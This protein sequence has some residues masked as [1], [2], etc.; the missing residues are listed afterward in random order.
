MRVRIRTYAL[1]AALA[2]SAA[3]PAIPAAALAQ[4]AGAP[5]AQAETLFVEAQKALSR[6]DAALAESILKDALTLDPAFTSAIWQLAQIYESQGKLDYARELLLR[7]LDQDPDASWAR[8]RLAKLEGT[9]ARALLADARAA[10]NAGEFDAA[11]PRLSSYLGIEPD[12]PAALVS[13][14]KCQLAKGR[15]KTAREYLARARAIDPDNAEL[16]SLTAVMTSGD[17]KE[18][19]EKLL[20]AAQIALLDTTAESP[21]KARAALG[22]LIAEDP[23][24]SWAKERLADLDRPSEAKPA[25]AHEGPIP[26]T[27]VVR[28]R[29]AA[30]RS[31]GVL[32]AAGRF[33][34]SHLALV[35]LVAV[36][37]A[38]VIDIRRKAARRAHPLEGTMSLVPVLD[39]VSLL[40]ANLR[41]GRLLVVN[42]DAKGE[43]FFEKGEIIH[44]TCGPLTG[45]LAFQKLMDLRSGRFFFHN[46][47]PNVRRTM[48][49][50]LSLLLLS[51]TPHEETLTETGAF[52]REKA[53]SARR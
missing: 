14:A 13:M 40:N 7:G 8:E 35:A 38:L 37:S 18:R 46:H 32:D 23:A 1:V 25:R 15:T 2:L 50:P 19:L 34:L 30:G 3:A 28:G 39:I 41:T 29:E 12:D 11:I 33:V 51:M 27:V 31:A 9:I 52:P 45:K 16:A 5:R 4:A 21:A 10:I 20:S 42:P 24:N 26:E 36:L 49:E 6:G 17:R 47:L 48:T 43:I 44:A 22:A 53:L